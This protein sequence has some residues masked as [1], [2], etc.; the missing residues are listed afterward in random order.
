MRQLNKIILHCTGTK[1]KQKVDV[2]DIHR[3]HLARGWNGIG[4]HFVILQDGTIQKGRAIGKVGAHALNN[5]HDT[6][7]V[8]Y[9]GGVDKDLKPKD[10]MTKAQA[11]SFRFLV[12]ALR[13]IHGDQIGVIGHNQVSS[14]ACPSFK[15]PNKFADLIL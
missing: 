12:K 10:T 11:E 8:A 15:V 14:K 6:V 9:C 1:A 13:L 5:N 3:W 4:Y 7:G 2:H